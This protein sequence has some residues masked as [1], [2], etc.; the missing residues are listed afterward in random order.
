MSK[1]IKAAM[2]T[3]GALLSLS[4]QAGGVMGAGVGYAD[5][6][7]HDNASGFKSQG[8][9]GGTFYA[10]YRFEQLPLLAELSYLDMG[11]HRLTDSQNSDHVGEFGFKGVNASVGVPL[12]IGRM[13]TTWIKAGYY[14]GNSDVRIDGLA[15]PLGS[16]IETRFTH[17]STGASAGLGADFML[18]P[19]LGLRFDY[20][21]L[22]EARDFTGGDLEGKSHLS[23]ASV[24]LTLAFGGGQPRATPVAEHTYTG[25]PAAAAPTPAAVVPVAVQGPAVLAGTV[26]RARPTLDAGASA[27]MA[28]ETSVQLMS[29]TEN[30]TGTWWYVKSGD[31][32]GWVQDSQ[33]HQ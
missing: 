25:M 4:A 29:K 15:A 7:R 32:Q 1:A 19:M 30:S 26:V 28:S 18:S 27:T 17:K 20:Q 8:T 23:L 5:D 14:N 13:V 9:L 2:V 11:S 21:V 24:G 10:G 3:A 33:V 22:F 12:R 16:G 6:L 31:V